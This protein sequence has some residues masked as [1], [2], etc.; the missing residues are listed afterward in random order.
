MLPMIKQCTGFR[1]K[2][3]LV[4]TSSPSSSVMHWMSVSFFT[5]EFQRGTMCVDN[6]SSF[7]YSFFRLGGKTNKIRS[8]KPFSLL[9][10]FASSLSSPFCIVP[11]TDIKECLMNAEFLFPCL[12]S[13][14]GFPLNTDSQNCSSEPLL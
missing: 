6:S 13:I 11:I 10:P 3:K 14:I 5:M 2:R 7:Q 1:I 12:S 4:G 9:S 8:I